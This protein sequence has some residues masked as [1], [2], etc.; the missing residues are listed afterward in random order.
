MRGSLCQE[1]DPALAVVAAANSLDP[2]QGQERAPDV[3]RVL[4]LWG[5]YRLGEWF[6]GASGRWEGRD[7]RDR[8]LARQVDGRERRVGVVTIRR[9]VVDRVLYSGGRDV[10]GDRR[11]EVDIGLVVV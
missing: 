8:R 6:R 1:V 9:G 4:V 7:V 3:F 5:R 11:G 2:P 10:G